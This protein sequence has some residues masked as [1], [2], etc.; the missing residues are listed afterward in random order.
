M[1]NARQLLG[2]SILGECIVQI[3]EQSLRELFLCLLSGTLEFN[4]MFASYKGEGTGAVRHMFSHHILKPERVPLEANLW[5]TPKSSGSFSTLFKSRILRAL[6]YAQDPFEV[7]LVHGA[8]K[9]GEK[10]FG[11]SERLGHLVAE[12]FSSFQASGEL[13]LSCGDSSRTDLETD[14]VDA[15]IT[16]PPFFD[17]VHYSQLADFFHVWQRHFL[18]EVGPLVEPT[19]RASAEVQNSEAAIFTAR[20]TAVWTECRRVLKKDGLLVFTYHHS[21]PEGWSSILKAVVD[22]GFAVVA[23]HPIKA[24]MSVATPKRQAK[25]PIDLDMIVVCRKCSARP[26]SPTAADFWP[27]VMAVA[28]RQVARL[29]STGRLLSRNDLRVIVMAQLLRQLSQTPRTDAA[30]ETLAENSAGIER[31]IEQLTSVQQQN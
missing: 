13:Y 28:T 9:S 16:D 17:N 22:A 15:V 3:E 29:R 18:G 24:E 27:E 8:R 21:R 11:L 23:A 14:S 6:E 4:N 1:F 20:L 30:L 26:A 10:V 31:A 19:T 25:E 5:G 7:R 12:D 2:L